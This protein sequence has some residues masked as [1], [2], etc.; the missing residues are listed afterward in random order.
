MIVQPM[1]FQMQ[2]NNRIHTKHT[3]DRLSYIYKPTSL[4]YNCLL[5]KKCTLTILLNLGGPCEG[6][7]L[8]PLGSIF[9]NHFVNYS[10][11]GVLT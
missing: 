5:D 4:K 8:G 7:E 9:G 6:A 2:Q 10:T 11:C 1:K 3:F